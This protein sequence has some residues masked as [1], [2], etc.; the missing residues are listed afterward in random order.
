MA[1]WVGLPLSTLGTQPFT[2]PKVMI[3]S[4]GVMSK[5]QT[6]GSGSTQLVAHQSQNMT[7]NSLM[8]SPGMGTQPLRALG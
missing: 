1:W 3:S 5:M 7:L 6:L 2:G 8:S 4:K